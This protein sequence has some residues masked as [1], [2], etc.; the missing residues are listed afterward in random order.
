M[1]SRINAKGQTIIPAEIR[2]RFNLATGDQLEWIVENDMI[3]VI[4]V[5]VN[6]IDAFRGSGDGGATARLLKDRH[7]ESKSE[8]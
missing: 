7:D 2:Q 4:P 1:K 6:P 8:I 5:R 3:R